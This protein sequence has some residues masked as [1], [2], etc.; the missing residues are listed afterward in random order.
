MN[1]LEPPKTPNLKYAWY[2]TFVLMFAYLSSF[3]DRQILNLLVT[4]MK[5][6]LELSDTEMSLLQGLSFAIF[7]TVLGIPIGRLAD[8]KN[9]K[10]IIIIGISVWSLMTAVCGVVKNYGQ[11]FLARVGVGVGE[12]ALSP[13]AYSMLTDYFPKE[14]LGTALSVYSMGIYLGS[15]FAVLIG[16]SLV[17]L[18]QANEMWTIP[19]FGEIFPWQ[20][21][22]FFVG[23][24]GFLIVLLMLTVKEPERKGKLVKKDEAGNLID[25]RV[26]VKEVLTY[27]GENR[28]AFLSISLGMAFISMVGYGGAAWIPTFFQRTY[29]WS[30]GKAGLYYG[31]VVTIFSTTGVVMGGR[32]ADYFSKKGQKHGKLKIGFIAGTGLL[33]TGW[34]FPLMPSGELAALFLILNCFLTAFPIGASAAAIQEMMPNQM[35]AMASSIYFF[36]LNIIALGIGPTVVA[37]FTD[38]A[39]GDESKVGYSLMALGLLGSSLTMLSLYLGFKPYAKTIENLNKKL[40]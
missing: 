11:F 34:I 40:I 33:L 26:S 39:F 28:T 9:R 7:Y 10:W 27:I 21:V 13:A 2:V 19:F 15:G 30:I 5:R 16:S 22:F 6:D 1:T 3:I 25:L 17:T 8:Y 12:A 35:R 32:L 18:V 31:L 38:F 36:I 23:L 20:S 14:K 24:P 4:P 29:G 37:L